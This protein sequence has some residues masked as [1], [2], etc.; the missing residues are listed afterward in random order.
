MRSFTRLFYTDHNDF[1]TGT[2]GDP[3]PFYS[4]KV[5]TNNYTD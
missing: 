1:Y 2:Q 4:I 3:L 5:I